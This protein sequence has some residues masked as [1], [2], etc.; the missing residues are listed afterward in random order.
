MVLEEVVDPRK[1]ISRVSR[2]TGELQYQTV[3]RQANSPHQHDQEMGAGSD[4]IES[5]EKQAGTHFSFETTEQ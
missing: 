4:I 3:A 5:E 2:N 1:Y